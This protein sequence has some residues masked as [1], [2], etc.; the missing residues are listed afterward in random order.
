MAGQRKGGREEGRRKWRCYTVRGGV[1]VR[2]REKGPK[3][4][5]SLYEVW[6]RQMSGNSR[7]G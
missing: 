3:T 1:D 6:G 4:Q 5:S 7:E 2:T